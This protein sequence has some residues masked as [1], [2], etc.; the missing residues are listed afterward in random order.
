MIRFSLHSRIET[1][2]RARVVR[3]L[4]A[5]ALAAAASLAAAPPAAA[6]PST[7][8][9]SGSDTFYRGPIPLGPGLGFTD[10]FSGSFVFDTSIVG[11]FEDPYSAVNIT[12]SGPLGAGTYTSA[13]GG[14]LGMRFPP[15]PAFPAFDFAFEIGLDNDAGAWMR[16][17]V[18][19]SAVG[20]S[21]TIRGP[22]LAWL[23]GPCSSRH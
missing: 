21:P 9:I 4:S 13:S 16:Y 6:T 22:I 20:A 7:W 19:L 11:P 1:A 12:V 14:A 10:T 3:R 5:L 8:K 15:L 17:E 2:F 18:T 23:F